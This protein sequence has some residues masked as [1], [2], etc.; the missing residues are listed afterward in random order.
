LENALEVK[1][2]KK[3]EREAKMQDRAVEMARVILKNRKIY[4]L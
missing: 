4:N 2:K 3:A 1:Q